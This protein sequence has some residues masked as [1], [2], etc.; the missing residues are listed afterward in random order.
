MTT[1]ATDK[2][3]PA[4]DAAVTASEPA[5]KT[6]KHADKR[7]ALGRGLESLLPT[8]RRA[9]TPRGSARKTVAPQPW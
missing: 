4:T 6:E 9:A 7:K 5:E 1:T 3:V 2:V 8:P